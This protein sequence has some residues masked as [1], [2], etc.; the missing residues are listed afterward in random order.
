[1]KASFMPASDAAIACLAEVRAPSVP[2]LLYLKGGI[3]HMKEPH[4]PGSY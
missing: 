4:W 2:E 1:M 3:E